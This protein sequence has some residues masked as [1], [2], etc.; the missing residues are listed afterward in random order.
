MSAHTVLVIVGKESWLG[1][2]VDI[3]HF[4]Q[5][6]GVQVSLRELW[7]LSLLNVVVESWCFI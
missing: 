7:K 4:L 6:K 5:G 3:R 1:C 2:V